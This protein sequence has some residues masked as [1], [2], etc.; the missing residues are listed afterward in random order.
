MSGP[1]GNLLGQVVFLATR[2]RAYHS[3]NAASY[4]V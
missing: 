1:G 3:A 4:R 2:D